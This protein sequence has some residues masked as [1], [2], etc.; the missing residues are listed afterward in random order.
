MV[1]PVGFDPSGILPAR[2]R[3]PR[4]ARETWADREHLEGHWRMTPEQVDAL[5]RI[6]LSLE[7]IAGV[8]ERNELRRSG[9]GAR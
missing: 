5:E 9:A 8:E 3:R 1:G 2:A 4:S 7:R 6:A